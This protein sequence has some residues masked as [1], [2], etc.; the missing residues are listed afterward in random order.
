MQFKVVIPARYDS[1]RFPG[2]VLKKIGKLS[3]LE[4][5]YNNAVKSNASEVFIATDSDIIFKEAGAF[6]NKVFMT[7]YLNKNG[8]ERVAELANIL[9]WKDSELVINLQ[10]DMPE[11]KCDNINYLAEKS[12]NNKGLS[13]LFYPLSSPLLSSDKNTVKIEVDGNS[14]NFYRVLSDLVD[15]TNIYKHIGIYAYQVKDLFLYKS[16]PQSENEISLS[17]EQCRF[18][19]NQLKI[20][21]YKAVSDPGISVD[22]IDNLNEIKSINN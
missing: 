3:M 5:V 6:T 16:Y 15:T 20:Q 21:A 1:S 7:S 8:T 2:K 12:I 10:A 22:S 19:D 13:T 9:R 14:I 18:L 4:C 17:L 11:L